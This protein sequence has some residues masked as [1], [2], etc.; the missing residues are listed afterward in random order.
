MFVRLSKVVR[1]QGELTMQ[2]MAIVR[3]AEGQ[4]QIDRPL[5]P[6]IVDT[7]DQEWTIYQQRFGPD[8][9]K[10]LRHL[11]DVFRTLYTQAAFVA[12]D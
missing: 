2:E 8:A 6:S 12:H 7:I 9:E 1:V 10:F 5:A 3:V 11:P 4:V